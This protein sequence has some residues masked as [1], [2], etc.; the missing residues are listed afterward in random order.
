MAAMK[1]TWMALVWAAALL[2]V[3][4]GWARTQGERP[5]EQ[6][7]GEAKN[8]GV[9]QASQRAQDR[10]RERPK[11]DELREG[12][13]LIQARTRLQFDKTAGRWVL[14]VPRAK[15]AEGGEERLIVLPSRVLSEMR[16]QI[17]SGPPESQAETWFNVRGRVS[18]YHGRRYVLVKH[19]SLGE[20]EETI[21]D[22][23]PGAEEAIT[24]GIA[25][26]QPA[27]A[28]ARASGDSAEDIAAALE[29]AAG[30][31]KR[32]SGV[33][34]DGSERTVTASDSDAAQAEGQSIVNRRGRVQRQSDG[35]WW[36][37]VFDAD[38]S[39]LGDP[40]VRLLPCTMLERMEEYVQRA[41]PN[42]VL[43]VTGSVHVYE[44]QRYVLPTVFQGV[45]DRR[46][47]MP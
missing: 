1:S 36:W 47:L 35:E 12:S 6:S 28:Q 3:G 29:K 25:G 27:Q 24:G 15:G 14:L 31:M 23:T 46:N 33:R 20:R 18:V 42:A 2:S 22:E 21:A 9:G 7:G 32:S 10:Q 26:S 16:E 38:A 34:A 30:T 43:L 17:E 39:G 4:E 11:S 40:P 13:H 45:R 41:G 8:A 5:R 37:F 44:G 19:A